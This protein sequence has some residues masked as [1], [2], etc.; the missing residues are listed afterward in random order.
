MEV[1]GLTV[2]LKVFS[3][4][5]A[6][7]HGQITELFDVLVLAE[8]LNRLDEILSETVDNVFF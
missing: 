1:T 7:R 5:F 6:T 3:E 4:D 2:F 8:L